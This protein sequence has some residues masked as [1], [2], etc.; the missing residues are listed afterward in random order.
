MRDNAGGAGGGRYSIVGR[1]LGRQETSNNRNHFEYGICSAG[2]EDRTG[3]PV[4]FLWGTVDSY[5]FLWTPLDSYGFLWVPMD[6]SGFLLI[7]KRFIC[8]PMDSYGLIWVPMDSYGFAL[9]R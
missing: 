7:V 8:I 9:I 2:G 1:P 3:D 4:G 6:P 5:G